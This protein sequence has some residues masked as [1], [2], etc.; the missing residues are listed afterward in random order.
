MSELFKKKVVF[1][2]YKQLIFFISQGAE[3]LLDGRGL[4][5]PEYP[6]GNFVGPTVIHNMNTSMRAYKEHTTF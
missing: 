4:T 5:V 1:I 2:P 3:L 6:N